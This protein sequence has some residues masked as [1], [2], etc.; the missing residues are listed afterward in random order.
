MG[1]R[2][3]DEGAVAG[4]EHGVVQAELRQGTGAAGFHAQDA[5]VEVDALGQVVDHH[6]DLAE[7]GEHGG[8]CPLAEGATAAAFA[9]AL[10]FQSQEF[11]FGFV[12]HP[13]GVVQL[14]FGDQS[15]DGEFLESALG[16]QALAFILPALPLRLLYLSFHR[17][18]PA[19]VEVGCQ[20][21]N[22]ALGDAPF[23]SLRRWRRWRGAVACSS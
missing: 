17:L 9:A 12:T 14:T 10:V 4:G 8:G 20:H 21:D 3:L 2:R 5:T 23:R 11:V 6:G 15:L 13:L 7:L 1:A 22:Y 19:G 16:F 18:D